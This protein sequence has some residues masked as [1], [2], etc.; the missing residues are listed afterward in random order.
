MADS[1]H[2]GGGGLF[3]LLVWRICWYGIVPVLTRIF[4][5]RRRIFR[6][7]GTEQ[8]PLFVISNHTTDR[9]PLF[10]G[11]SFQ[12]H[13][14]YVA[15]EHVLRL[16][17]ASGLLRFFFNP[18]V[19]TKGASDTAALRDM[20][21]RLKAG[22]NLCL[23]AEGNR[24]FS[25]LTG[26][27]PESTGKLVRLAAENAGA[28][29]VTYRIQGGYF[30]GPRWGRRMRR[31]PVW[32]GPVAYYSPKTLLSMPV[33]GINAR[34]REDIYEDAYETQKARPRRYRS[35]RRAEDLETGLYLCPCCGTIGK[36]HSRGDTLSCACGFSCRYD[37]YGTLH[38]A[39]FPAGARPL[40]EPFPTVRDWWRWQ[41]EALETLA[42]SPGE[43][44]D[45]SDEGERLF[46]VDPHTGKRELSRGRLS[47]GK[48]GLR[49]GAVFF[50]LAAL[51]GLA[52][53]GQRT[54][55]FLAGGKLYE[56]TNRRPRSAA[57]YQRLF[58]ILTKNRKE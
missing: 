38:N 30:A 36:L 2:K 52:I 10:V 18:V 58:E 21:N 53:T 11:S 56:L 12:G 54:M 23:F 55:S 4:H 57:K 8:A 45:C 3:H 20:V 19:I 46:L 49:C 42:A 44:P 51:N 25:G 34:I 32:G 26:E 29:L 35:A 14:Y 13:L 33:T 39:P 41:S 15:S 5:Y 37:E 31:G 6:P 40:H 17:W 9:D 47:L 7:S 1:P 50:P 24:S 22:R 48:E 43:T 16:G 27:I 28:A